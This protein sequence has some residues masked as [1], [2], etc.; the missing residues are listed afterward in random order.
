MHVQADHVPLMENYVRAWR[1]ALRRGDPVEVRDLIIH[2]I[3]RSFAADGPK[4]RIAVAAAA[5]AMIHDLRGLPGLDHGFL[6]ERNLRELSELLEQVAEGTEIDVVLCG[7]DGESFAHVNLKQ[8]MRVAE[9]NAAPH[10]AGARWEV[11]L[12]PR[13]R[14]ERPLR[15][16]PTYLAIGGHE[17]LRFSDDKLAPFERG[18]CPWSEVRDEWLR[19]FERVVFRALIEPMCPIPLRLA[20]AASADVLIQVGRLFIQRPGVVV[21]ESFPST[22]SL[23]IW[24]DTLKSLSEGEKLETALVH[25]DGA[26]LHLRFSRGER[27]VLRSDVGDYLDPLASTFARIARSSEII[28]PARPARQT[29]KV[30]RNQPCPC[31]SGSKYKRCCGRDD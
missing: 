9:S 4:V 25:D 10:I 1:E 20:S 27:T 7:A 13:P 18:L 3:Q 31:G 29:P 17:V 5:L 8:G 28:I 2:T 11:K 16:T 15:F 21:D 14:G 30:S 24:S 22:E 6:S 23:E 19:T 26:L 12:G